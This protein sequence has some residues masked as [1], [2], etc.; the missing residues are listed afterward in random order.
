MD[1]DVIIINRSTDVDLNK[2]KEL[3]KKKSEFFDV[4]LL[5]EPFKG[6]LVGYS[7]G[8]TIAYHYDNPNFSEEE[9][10]LKF[11]ELK[12]ELSNIFNVRVGYIN[13]ST[14]AD[15][16]SGQYLLFDRNQLL[17]KDYVKAEELLLDLDLK[18]TSNLEQFLENEYHKRINHSLAEN[19]Y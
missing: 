4:L 16:P 18:S 11:D 10:S 17:C 3:A 5:K 15:I 14:F 19:K 9:T 7:L 6:I 8:L 13:Y 1:I 2:I 12:I